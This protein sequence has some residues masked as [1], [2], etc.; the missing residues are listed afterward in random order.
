M[1]VKTMKLEK[2]YEVVAIKQMRRKSTKGFKPEELV[3]RCP[4]DAYKVANKFIGD[5]AREVVLVMMLNTKNVVTAVHIAHIGSLNSSIVHP[6]EVFQAAIL[7]N[8]ASIIV[9]HQHPSGDPTP[10]REDINVTKRL[11]EAGTIIGIEVL[12]HVIVG[13]GKYFSLKEKGYM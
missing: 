3:I 12:D 10:S 7:N 13:Y 4:E 2:I 9:A 6:R 1:E 11:V 8:A 5:Y